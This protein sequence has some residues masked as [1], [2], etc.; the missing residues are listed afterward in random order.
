LTTQ[1]QL[2]DNLVQ[3][4]EDTIAFRFEAVIPNFQADA[5]EIHSALIDT[6]DRLSRIER[7]LS[8]AVRVKAAADRKVAMFK[9]NYQEQWDRAIVKVNSRPTL[10]EYAT[11]KEKAAEANLA[12]LEVQRQL[13]REE[14]LQSFANEA[15]DVIKLHYYGLDKVRQDLRKR[16]DLETQAQFNA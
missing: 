14:E 13:R 15:V 3:Y 5:V 6:Q 9:M 12:T 11:G 7:L 10:N 16:L 4:I 1:N 2:Q 8:N